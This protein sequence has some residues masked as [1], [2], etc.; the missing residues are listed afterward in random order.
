MRP[1]RPPLG[2]TLIELILAV[3]IALI[4]LGL[5]FSL[6]HTLSR[7]VDDQRARLT[8]GTAM[9]HALEQLTRDLMSSMPVPG[10]DEG[11]FLLET[12]Q[13]A[14]GPSSHVAFCTARFRPANES[15]RD[16]ADDPPDPREARDLRW[17]DIVEVTY[18]LEYAP[19]E[20][21]RLIR[22]ERPLTGPAALEP[23]RTNVL[24]TGVDQFHVRV[25]HED[26]WVDAW[27]V[28]PDDEE[29]EWPRAARI[30]VDPDDRARGAHAQTVDVLIPAGWTMEREPAG[31]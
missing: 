29:A 25:R 27:E 13:A 17:F 3:S 20:R 28:D 19:R 12:E 18:S 30:T 6:Y 11:G 21:G 23:A 8:G 10:Y 15:P 7:T 9:M 16:P 5:V 24:A 22:T 1:R 14:R 26:E 4:L 2:F 31:E